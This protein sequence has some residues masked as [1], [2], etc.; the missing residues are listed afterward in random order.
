MP[1][2]HM[3]TAL[4]LRHARR[5]QRIS[6][7]LMPVRYTLLRVMAL[8]R[9]HVYIRRRHAA[10]YAADADVDYATCRR[11][12]ALAAASPARHDAAAVSPHD[13]AITP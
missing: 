12:A 4:P 8:L 13:A 9:C 11:I 10:V 6:R 1:P 7:R 2:R 5:C 3:P